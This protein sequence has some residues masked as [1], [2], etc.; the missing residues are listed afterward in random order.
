MKI[1]T[2]FYSD[3]ALN[4]P[5]FENLL[6][7]WEAK[8]AEA[9]FEP[10]VIRSSIDRTPSHTRLTEAVSRF[11]NINPVI[12]NAGAF[13]RW[14][15]MAILTAPEPATPVIHMDSDV[16]PG[17]GVDL[18]RQPQAPGLEPLI[19][20]ASGCPCAVMANHWGYQALLEAAESAEPPHGTLTYSDQEM[21]RQ[22]GYPTVDFV[23]QFPNTDRPLIHFST[24]AMVHAGGHYKDD[25]SLFVSRH[26]VA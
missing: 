25:K 9:G 12:Y 1:Y 24:S 22:V 13:V 21:C 14:L 10:I 19:L 16:F 5:G 23:A 17:P 11:P 26:Y 6:T 18:I 2:A 8:W 7:L 3:P 20:D 15:D 4:Q